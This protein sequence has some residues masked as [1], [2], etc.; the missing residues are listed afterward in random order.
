MFASED[1]TVRINVALNMKRSGCRKQP[2]RLFIRSHL[3]PLL[4]ILKQFTKKVS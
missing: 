3:K 4:S 1:G 2:L